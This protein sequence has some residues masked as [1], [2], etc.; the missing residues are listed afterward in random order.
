MRSLTYSSANCLSRSALVAMHLTFRARNKMDI[1]S[2]PLK[3]RINRFE[4]NILSNSNEIT[5]NNNYSTV[6]VVKTFC[7]KHLVCVESDPC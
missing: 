2:F 7:K 4:K 5:Q 3:R 6:I 1:T